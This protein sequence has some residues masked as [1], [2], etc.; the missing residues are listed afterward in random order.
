M[1]KFISACLCMIMLVAVFSVAAGASSWIYSVDVD[2]LELPVA[3]NLPD[4]DADVAGDNYRVKEIVWFDHESGTDMRPTDTFV[5]GGSYRVMV[6]LTTE[7]GYTFNTDGYGKLEVSGTLNGSSEDVCLYGDEEEILLQYDFDPC[8]NVRE[9]TVINI[10]SLTE[11]QPGAKAAYTAV[12][13][14]GYFSEGSTNKFTNGI[15]WYDETASQTLVYLSSNSSFVAGHIYSVE[16]ILN[17]DYAHMFSENVKAYINGNEATVEYVDESSI[18]VSFTFDVCGGLGKTEKITAVQN[19]NT[20]ALT[21]TPVAG[22]DG[23]RVFQ[24]VSGVWKKLGNTTYTTATINKLSAGT[25]YSFAVL[26]GKI[27][28]GGVKWADTYTVIDTATQAVKPAKVVSVQNTSA[29]KLTWTASAGATGYRV[30]YKTGNTWTVCVSSTAATSHTFKN[31]KA[32]A[33]DTFA[34]RPYILNGGNV[35][36][37]AYTEF[38]AATNP[39][40][41][42]AKA[43][44]PSKGKITLTWNKVNG[45]DGYQVYYKTGNGAYKLYKTVNASTGSLAF[46]N[47]KSGTKYTFAVRAGIKTSGG[48]IFGAYKVA[49]VTVK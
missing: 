2:G 23:Y 4:Y 13:G 7:F 12:A 21:W 41:V 36:W 1:K 6:Y 34:V 43:S 16:I 27:T 37:S 33:K 48:N 5:A 18:N 25:K 19:T 30:Y 10:N 31:L 15:K 3:G 44:S 49:T 9:L 11:P 17:C 8:E 24:N 22:A 39:A 26:A 20:I 38:T 40:T 45:A 42:T 47:L 32:G 28:D 35:I 46:S 29:I 14:E